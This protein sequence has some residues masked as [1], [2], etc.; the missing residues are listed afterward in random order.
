MVDADTFLKTDREVF[1]K[2]PLIAKL[3]HR[4]EATP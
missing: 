1:V 2:R 3:P 4:N